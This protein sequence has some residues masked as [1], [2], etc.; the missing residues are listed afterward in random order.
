MA[1]LGNQIIVVHIVTSDNAAV[2]RPRGASDCGLGAMMRAHR[3]GGEALAENRREFGVE[4]GDLVR[5]ELA[6]NAF[7]FSSA[8]HSQR[9]QPFI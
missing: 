2:F 9:A 3:V 1:R 5:I 7:L 8:A 4:G 6:A